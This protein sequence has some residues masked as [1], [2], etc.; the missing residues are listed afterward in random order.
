MN[1]GNAIKQV[2]Q[3]FELSQVELRTMTGIAQTS[4][5]QIES[6]TKEPSKKTIERICAALEIPEMVLY[7]LGMESADVP[8]SRRGVYNELYP[9]MK[10]FAKQVLGK[11]KSA[12]L[13]KK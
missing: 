8:S 3:H 1:I 11:R 9:A 13:E 7:V 10:D 12:L 6:G 2:R 5:S 4:I